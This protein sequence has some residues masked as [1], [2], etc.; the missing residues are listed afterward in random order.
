MAS[1]LSATETEMMEIDHGLDY[2]REKVAT[3]SWDDQ[4]SPR[5]LAEL[6]AYLGATY[7]VD[8]HTRAT[9]LQAFLT[10]M[11]ARQLIHRGE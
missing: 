3:D 5:T 10:E 1:D 9:E 11:E 7:A 8:D 6:Q 2:G 4:A